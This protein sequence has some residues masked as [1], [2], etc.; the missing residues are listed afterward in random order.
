MELKDTFDTITR[1]QRADIAA[2]LESAIPDHLTSYQAQE[3]LDTGELARRTRELI[4]KMTGPASPTISDFEILLNYD[5]S[6]DDKIVRLK[7]YWGTL[8]SD[9]VSSANFPRIRRGSYRSPVHTVCFPKAFRAMIRVV[10]LLPQLGLRPA[11]AQELIDFYLHDRSVTR[12]HTVVGLGQECV[13]GKDRLVP[14][15]VE[16]DQGQRCIFLCNLNSPIP[17]P[18]SHRFLFGS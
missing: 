17:E 16:G 8:A 12:G 5:E 9:L 15:I 6:L 10:P 14:A 7:R 11:D 1:L 3:L 2:R 18:K 4:I 13:Q